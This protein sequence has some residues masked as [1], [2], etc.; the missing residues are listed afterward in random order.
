MPLAEAIGLSFVAPLFALLLAG[1]LLGERIR[2]QA[3][4]A[5][6]AGIVGVAIILAGRFGQ[7]SYSQD[8]LLGVAAVLV[9]TAFYGFNLILARKQAQ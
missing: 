6:L 2:K 3:I 9:S 1:L 5:S 4:W 8:A 7:A